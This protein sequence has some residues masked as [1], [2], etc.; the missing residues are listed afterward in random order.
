MCYHGPVIGEHGIQTT[1]I[2]GH[3][4]GDGNTYATQESLL[5]GIEGTCGG[6]ATQLGAVRDPLIVDRYHI[7]EV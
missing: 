3:H 5:A 2:T 6:H 4:I 1:A 7:V